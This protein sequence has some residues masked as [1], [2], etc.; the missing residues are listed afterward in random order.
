[1]HH[2]SRCSPARTLLSGMPL[3]HLWSVA[4]FAS[5]SPRGVYC[6]LAF[7]F[8]AEPKK[9]VMLCVVRLLS[10]KALSDN[11]VSC[12]FMHGSCRNWESVFTVE[13]SHGETDERSNNQPRQQE[14]RFRQVRR[15]ERD[16]KSG[17]SSR[18]LPFH[19][20]RRLSLP[21][22]HAQVLGLPLQPNTFHTFGI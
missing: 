14:F 19:E 12:A 8:S 15:S 17:P 10:P 11:Q 21:A 1:M 16:P 7:A 18:K 9:T 6:G 22:P 13:D 5:P 20:L 4:A 2:A 3:Q